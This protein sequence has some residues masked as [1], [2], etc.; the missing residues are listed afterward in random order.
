MGDTI[1]LSANVGRLFK[2][3]IDGRC[4]LCNIYLSGRLDTGHQRS[5]YKWYFAIVVALGILEVGNLDAEGSNG[6][7]VANGIGVVGVPS[8]VEGIPIVHGPIVVVPPVVVIAYIGIGV[9]YVRSND[10]E[11]GLRVVFDLS[12]ASGGHHVFDGLN[13]DFG[14]EVFAAEVFGFALLIVENQKAVGNV[15]GAKRREIALVVVVGIYHQIAR[16]FRCVGV[17][18]TGCEGY[19]YK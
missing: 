7:G 11:I 14:T 13:D 5:P 10:T 18:F 4:C 8:V 2:G 6:V 9:A 12:V 15:E 1:V 16:Q 19:C 3:L 17:F